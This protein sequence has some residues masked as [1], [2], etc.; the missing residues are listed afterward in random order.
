M[1]FSSARRTDRRSR[2]RQQE[3]VDR[4]R[5]G[6]VRPDV[7]RVRRHH[8]PVRATRR[9][10]DPK[11]WVVMD[12]ECDAAA[13]S[14]RSST[15]TRASSTRCSGR[16]ASSCS[17]SSTIRGASFLTTDHPNGAPFT[18][19]PHLIRLLM[20][21]HV[22]PR[23]DADDQSGRAEV[24]D[25][26]ASLDREYTLYEIAIMTRAGPATASACGTAGIWA[27]APAADITVYDDNPDRE[28]MFTTPESLFKNGE[29]IVRNGKIVKVVNGATHVTRAV[30]RSRHREVFEELFR[31]LSHG[32]HGKLPPIRR[33]DRQA[34]AAARCIIQPTRARVAMSKTVNGVAIDDTFAEAFGMSGTRHHHH[35]RYAE[36]GTHRGNRRDGLRHVSHRLR[37]G[38]RYRQGISPDETPDGRPGVRILMFGFSPDALVPQIR[39]RIGQ[40]VLTSPGS[41]CYSGLKSDKHIG[42]GKGPRFF[43]DGFQTAKR[44]GNTPLL[45]RSRDGRRVRRRGRHGANDRRCRRRQHA[46]PRK[47]TAPAFSK[48]RK[49]LS[50][51]SPRST[52]SSRH[53]PAASYARAGRSARNTRACLR[54]PT[55]RSARRFAARSKAELGPTRSRFSK[56]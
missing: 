22:P 28:A 43:G 40:C 46:D 56:S 41:A 44:L 9:S 36:M 32:A 21:K 47:R 24:F 25:A 6:H 39:N 19:Y 4:H 23:Q 13:A 52:T 17:Y 35:G 42:L 48:R 20:D 49:R 5:P 27:S 51:R 11:K 3:R 50:R 16:S 12:I 14:C 33:G 34:A 2:Q 8:A 31:R 38:M 1:K 29:M 7:H 54:R 55:M 18:W 15:A 53:S 45:A 10:A 26:E 30:L 37:R